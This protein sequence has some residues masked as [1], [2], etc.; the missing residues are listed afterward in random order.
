MLNM[1]HTQTS[2]YMSVFIIVLALLV[3]AFSSILLLT[4]E[5]IWTFRIFSLTHLI[6]QFGVLGPNS[7]TVGQHAANTSIPKQFLN[8][9]L[10]FT[11]NLARYVFTRENPLGNLHNR[12]PG[13]LIVVHNINIIITVGLLAITFIKKPVHCS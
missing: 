12:N 8:S 6:I 10:I 9:W 7:P 3:S 13:R 1:V 2:L 4:Q 5:S 11:A